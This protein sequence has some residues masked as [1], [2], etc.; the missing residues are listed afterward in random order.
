MTAYIFSNDLAS[1]MGLNFLT[2]K[3]AA[4]IFVTC[5]QVIL[6]SIKF[7]TQRER[8]VSNTFPIAR[9]LIFISVCNDSTS[10]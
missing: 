3:L 10:T 2:G 9:F 8:T 1:E 6:F 4:W 5:I 7:W